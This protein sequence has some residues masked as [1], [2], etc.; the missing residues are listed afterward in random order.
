[1]KI[2]I[3]SKPLGLILQNIPNILANINRRQKLIETGIDKKRTLLNK[4]VKLTLLFLYI[5]GF[6]QPVYAF[7]P[8]SSFVLNPSLY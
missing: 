3:F 2:I 5:L 1:M 6:G 7:S 8:Q 4:I